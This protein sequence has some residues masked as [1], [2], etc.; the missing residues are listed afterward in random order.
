V[1]EIVLID[2]D[3]ELHEFLK[4]VFP[5]EIK[6]YSAYSGKEGIARCD[7]FFPDL[8][9]LDV[10][11]SDCDGFDILTSIKGT[12]NSPSVIVYSA[13]STPPYVVKAMKLGATDFL[14]KPQ[15]M[16]ELKNALFQAVTARSIMYDKIDDEVDIPE[17]RTFVGRSKLIQKVKHSILKYAKSDSSLLITGESGTGKDVIAEL[18]HS[19]SDR[20]KGPYLAL[21]CGAIPGTI[22]ESELFG[23]NRG[24]FTDA[25]NKPGSFELANG[26]TLFLDEIGEMEIHS[27]VKLLRVIEKKQVVHVG[28]IHSIP[29]DVRIIAAT[30]SILEQALKNGTFREDLYYRINTLMIHIPPLRERKE[31]IPLLV[32]HFLSKNDT[33]YYISPLAMEKLL[34][35]TWPGNVRELRNVLERSILFAE[36]NMIVPDHIQFNRCF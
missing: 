10:D 14:H 17:L 32:D 25:V 20:K 8:V 28:G 30:N 36:D 18:V 16:Y 4:L 34:D 21:N 23:S 6:L 9:L 31:D 22:L 13:K 24:A 11:L 29:V 26:G 3:R 27:Q 12:T 5:K 7:E 1:I 19:L 15:S 35:H 33:E 2:E